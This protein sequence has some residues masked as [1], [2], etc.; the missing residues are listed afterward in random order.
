M[1][2]TNYSNRCDE[3]QTSRKIDD[4]SEPSIEILQT[5]FKKN[6]QSRQE[7]LIGK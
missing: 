1:K 6:L 4:D 7:K 2:G 3:K 5:Q